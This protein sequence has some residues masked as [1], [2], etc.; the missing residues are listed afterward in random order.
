VKFD[1]LEPPYF[2]L[3][4]GSKDEFGKFAFK[5]NY[6]AASENRWRLAI[7]VVRGE[8]MKT[9][10]GLF[11]EFAA[12]LQFPD[13]FG[14]NWAALD[15]CLSD[16]EW[17]PSEGYAVLMSNSLSVL[18]EEDPEDRAILP[19]L[20]ARVCKFWA[21]EHRVFPSREL[22]PMPFHVVFHATEPEV[23]FVDGLLKPHSA[24]TPTIF[25]R[26]IQTN[27]GVSGGWPGR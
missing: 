8:K 20:L 2:Y 9:R 11:D 5:L 19:R 4:V 10:A 7:R 17:M 23:D 18:S 15:E 25:L 6:E 3:V 16:L 24:D 22:K 26:D 14:E 12:A 21:T 27:Q 13:Y 1:S